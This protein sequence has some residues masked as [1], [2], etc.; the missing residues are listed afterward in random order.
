MG[1]TIS[2]VVGEIGLALPE[3]HAARA[4][5]M[6]DYRVGKKTFATY[7][8]NHHGDGRIALWLPLPPGGQ[9]HWVDHDPEQF[10]VPPYVGPRGWLG[11]RLDRAPDWDRVAALV[12][13]AFTH[14]A[15]ARL[16]RT[17]PPVQPVEPPTDALPAE[18]I[19]PLAAPGAAALVDAL[20]A[21]CLGLPE[22]SEVRQFGQPAWRAGRKTF[23]TVHRHR[24]RLEIQCWV[25]AE[26]QA[27]LTFDERYRIPPY[28]G[29]NGWIAL[30][31][32]T[33]PIREEIQGLVLGSYRHFAL[34]RM[35]RAL[36]G[37]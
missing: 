32:E 31:V 23:C 17:L 6:T 16:A 9:A 27:M 36:D 30:D 2:D 3:T 7:A 25:G 1:R 14:V 15:P 12:R 33:D 11:V 34:Q 35:L 26:Q 10:F 18:V 28:I 8:I 20:R 37:R 4:H 13:E 5:G 19:D 21:Y 22:V 29:H 24:G